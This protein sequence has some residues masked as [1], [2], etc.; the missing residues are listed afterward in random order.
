MGILSKTSHCPVL[1]TNS[2]ITPTPLGL[3]LLSTPEADIKSID[4][5]C[6]EEI[7]EFFDLGQPEE[8]NPPDCDPYNR[9]ALYPQSDVFLVPPPPQF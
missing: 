8:G 3:G 4:R 7:L 5:A 6:V 9:N 1:L 2:F